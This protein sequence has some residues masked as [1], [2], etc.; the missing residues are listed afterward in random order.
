[1]RDYESRNSLKISAK[2]ALR[3]KTLAKG[4]ID[5]CLT[6]LGDDA[7]ANVDAASC[8]KRKRQVARDC[9]EH[10]AEHSCRL[11]AHRVLGVHCQIGDLGCRVALGGYAIDH[12][13]TIVEI[14]QP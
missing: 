3:L 11:Y 8:A 9:P 14:D 4:R 12:C 2:P 7:T 13:E 1:M 6:E 10:R 5:K